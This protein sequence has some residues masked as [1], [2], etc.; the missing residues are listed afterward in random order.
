MVKIN[1]MKCSKRMTSMSIDECKWCKKKYCLNCLAIEI[2][3]CENA[4]ICRNEKRDMLANTLDKYKTHSTK[5]Y[6]VI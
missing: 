2:H 1:C 5:N 6:V 3:L 4:E